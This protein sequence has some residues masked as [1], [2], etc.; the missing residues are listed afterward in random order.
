MNEESFV[1][2]LSGLYRPRADVALGIG[3]D[4]AALDLGLPDDMLLLAAVDQVA[5]GVHFL[6][7]R[8]P[9][10]VAS[11]LLKRNL[12]DIA[13]MGGF[14]THS[15]LT[16]ALFP[17]DEAWLKEFH[18]SLAAETEKYSLSLIGG[19]FTRLASQGKVCTLTILGKVE[20]S[21]LCVRSGARAGDYLYATGVFG[22]S[23]V[24]EWHLDFTPRLAEGRFL[25]GRFTNAMMDVSDGLA[26]DVSRMAQ[27]SNLAC[28]FICD[29]PRRRGATLRGAFTDGEDYELIFSVD[30][31]KCSVLEKEWPFETELTRIG[32]FERG[33]AGRVF[34]TCLDGTMNTG[35][36]H[37]NGN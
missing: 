13:S 16:T 22:N 9:V 18:T 33:P 36:D 11:K 23:F 12:S 7:K 15:L 2:F 8:D 21:R 17:F 26:K 3:D 34:N 31:E 25:A 10:R 20:K 14:P 1:S 4:C 37:F 6:E 32:L 30:P 19:D 28:R 27:A 5:E 35:F 24:S 29:P